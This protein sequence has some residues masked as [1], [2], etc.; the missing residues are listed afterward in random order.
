M[1]L[2]ALWFVGPDLLVKAG[3]VP[4]TSRTFYSP[5]HGGVQGQ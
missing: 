5:E 4:D 2:R 3:E 1:K